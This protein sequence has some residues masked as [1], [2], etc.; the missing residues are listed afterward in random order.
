MDCGL[1]YH[2]HVARAAKRGLQTVLALER[3]RG[4]RPNT[5][6]QLYKAT[7]SPVVDY[8]SRVWSINLLSKLV[9]LANQVQRIGLSPLLPVSKPS[10]YQWQKRR[11]RWM[12]Q[13]RRSWID[14]H[15]L[16]T[17]HPLWEVLQRMQGTQQCH[18]SV[19]DRTAEALK[20]V[21]LRDPD[22]FNCSAWHLGSLDHRFGLRNENEQSRW[23][24][25]RTSEGPFSRMH[26]ADGV[27]WRSG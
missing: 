10:H 9:R 14:L 13:R 27:S 19:L 1:R 23:P 16:S 12:T 4:L 24:L 5:V 21:D 7:V 20:D 11:H 2:A 26:Q 6:R 8:A 18:R 17:P 15:T 3:L 25:E 22:V